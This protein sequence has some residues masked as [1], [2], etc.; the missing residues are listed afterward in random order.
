MR[1]VDS[2]FDWQKDSFTRTHDNGTVHATCAART[3]LCDD[4]DQPHL[5]DVAKAKDGHAHP[6]LVGLRREVG[7]LRLSMLGYVLHLEDELSMGIYG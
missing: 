3:R 1:P 6:P 4:P 2:V 5:I 7:Y